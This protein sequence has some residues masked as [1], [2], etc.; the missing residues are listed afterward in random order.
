MLT[1][2]VAPAAPKMVEVLTVLVM[3]LPPEVMV[4][5]MR[6]VEIGTEAPPAP[7]PEPVA[8]E[9][10]PV[11]PEPEPVAPEPEAPAPVAVKADGAASSV[12]LDPEPESRARSVERRCSMMNRAYTQRST[13]RHTR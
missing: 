12:V 11:A 1:L 4:L 3:V 5:T 8:P 9:P 2:T 6:V 7:E 13:D 10:E